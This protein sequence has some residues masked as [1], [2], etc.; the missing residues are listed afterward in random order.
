[1]MPRFRRYV[2]QQRCHLEGQFFQFGKPTV[3][4]RFGDTPD[5]GTSGI[6]VRADHK[7]DMPATPSA[8]ADAFA[9]NAFFFHELCLTSATA[10]PDQGVNVV[11]GGAIVT[12]GHDDGDAA[13]A[14]GSMQINLATASPGQSSA[15]IDIA[16]TPPVATTVPTE[17][18][19]SVQRLL[20]LHCRAT[21]RKLTGNQ[22]PL[23]ITAFIGGLRTNVALNTGGWVDNVA[24]GLGFRLRLD[25]TGEGTW[26]AIAQ[27]D[28]FNI[29]DIDTGVFLNYDNTT[30]IVSYQ[31]YVLF[32]DT[33]GTVLFFI[34]RVL[35]AEIATN[36]PTT[37]VAGWGAFMHHE[38]RTDAHVLRVDDLLFRGIR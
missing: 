36:I 25:A 15:I 10:T 21:V 7:H 30:G 26:H 35:V 37:K 20:E 4:M 32:V 5:E 14:F 2:S 31:D 27:A 17:E 9:A 13:G 28:P 33:D 22:L 3:A 6:L 38:A 11:Q 8:V 24:C 1:M 29:T 19:W 18:V 12:G 34:D 23:A 16:N